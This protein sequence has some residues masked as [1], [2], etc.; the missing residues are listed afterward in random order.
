M[1]APVSWSKA[2]TLARLSGQLDCSVVLPMIA[3]S[4]SRWESG[5]DGFLT[6]I[7]DELGPGPFAVRSSA[8]NE[9]LDGASNAGRYDSFL[10]VALAD[11]GKSVSAVFDSIGE[12]EPEDEVFLQPMVGEVELAGVAFSRDPSTGSDYRVIEYS[13]GADPTAVTAGRG[14]SRMLVC[15]RGADV[16]NG[17]LASVVRSI[18][19]LE[20]LHPASAL[21]IEFVFSRD[22]DK[23]V[24]LQVRPLLVG[25]PALTVEEHAEVLERV[26]GQVELAQRPHPFLSGRTTVFGVMPD[27]NPAE[28]IGIRPRPLSMSLYRDVVTD[29]IWAYQRSNYG[30]RNLR[31]H[32]LMVELAGQPYIDV[33]V[34]FNSFVP[35]DLTS[36]LA[37]R[38]VDH[39]MHQLI[40][41]PKHHD[42]VEF[43][44]VHS[45]FVLG[46]D[47]RLDGLRRSGFSAN[48]TQQLGDALRRLT[49]RIIDPAEGLWKVDWDRIERLEARR[50]EV[51]DSDLDI[52]S[53]IHWLLEDCKRYGTLPFAGLARCGFI[54]RQILDSL[55]SVGILTEDRRVEFLSS[56]KTVN[57]RLVEA[58]LRGDRD[59]FLAEFGHLRPGTYELTSRRYDESP[60]SYF[61]FDQLQDR[62]D[63][64]E[65]VFELSASEAN[66]IDL[67]MAA[68]GM[69]G[70][71]RSLLEFIRAGI[72]L[73][74]EAKFQF[75][76]NVSD[77]MVHLSDWGEQ[78]GISRDDMSFVQIGCI[79]DA[80]TTSVDPGPMLAQAASRGRDSYRTCEAVWLP[81]LVVEPA[82]V[83]CFEISDDEAN[84]VTQKSVVAETGQ[85]HERDSVQG[86]IAM[87][88]S[89]DPGYDWLF[90]AGIV[91]LVTAYGGVNSHMAIRS[92]ELGL[93]AA[94]GIGEQRFGR[95]AKASRLLLDCGSRRIEAIE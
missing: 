46:M 92:H 18:E 68:E 32:P 35:Q 81:S 76:R 56:I 13:E 7:E 80:L 64:S 69:T 4:R 79:R 84:F 12:L 72:E 61:D 41:L 43:E 66:D 44:I 5:E 63:L 62:A 42:K 95:L 30:Y 50:T 14:H 37:S 36:D 22:Y 70:D 74:E 23:L 45:C 83:S 49:N 75:T 21:D 67:R 60:D 82:D 6:R 10:D 89:A 90:A 8:L 34:S 87:V 48:D 40:E 51:E 24:L 25:V 38:L 77:F 3:V 91:G 29:T 54:S 94:I 27:W 28:V 93:P 26:A 19:E 55:S 11:A 57:S 73:R 58:H 2:G 1:T 17:Q 88:P 59:L 86:C 20:K 78:H 39:Y 85:P 9:D 33:R 53:R 65:R 16:G 15:L 31:G 47:E 52:V 71:S